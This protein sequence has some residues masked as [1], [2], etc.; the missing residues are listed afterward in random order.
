[1]ETGVMW[2]LSRGEI[3]GFRTEKRRGGGTMGR[4]NGG[5][6]TGGNRHKKIGRGGRGGRFVS[7]NGVGT[8]HGTGHITNL[9]YYLIVCCGAK[10]GEG[11][12]CGATWRS[13]VHNLRTRTA[14]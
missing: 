12:V 9:A 5:G 6:G 10:V 14:T 1:M 3:R 11:N 4:K 7:K 8:Q 13:K 2:V